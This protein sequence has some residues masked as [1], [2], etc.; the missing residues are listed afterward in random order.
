MSFSA[1]DVLA[2]PYGFSGPSG[3]G[4]VL[5]CD[6]IE[7]AYDVW[8]EGVGWGFRRVPKTAGAYHQAVS[9]AGEWEIVRNE[10]LTEKELAAYR[11]DLP[12]RLCRHPALNWGDF[13]CG[14][15]DDIPD[16]L[17]GRETGF[18]IDGS[19]EAPSV[20]LLFA[21]GHSLTVKSVKVKA[22]DGRRVPIVDLLW[23]AQKLIAEQGH[24]APD[25]IGLFRMVR[26]SGAPGYFVGGYHKFST[27]HHLGGDPHKFPEWRTR[28]KPV[29]GDL[30]ARLK[31]AKKL[32]PFDSWR[33]GEEH[34]L[35]QYSKENCD[36]AKA[37]FDRLIKKLTV[38]GE[39]GA[40]A[41]KLELFREA[42]EELNAL[43]AEEGNLIETGERDQ[44]CELFNEIARAVGLD[45]ANYGGGEGPA[46]LWRDW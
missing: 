25:G 41:A 37:I 33:S 10:P 35:D 5:L 3:L 23:N 26:W 42:V 9:L 18:P 39:Q 38:L 4:R 22:R 46:S 7:F 24:E 14:S 12:M 20:A 36:A 6:E 32:Y 11:P 15:A 13:A 1:G 43:D 29:T 27:W 44:L 34:G 45:P 2:I 16:R 17:A 28:R 8:S 31:A 30:K 19:I 21:A 40:E